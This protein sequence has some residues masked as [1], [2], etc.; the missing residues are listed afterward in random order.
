MASIAAGRTPHSRQTAYGVDKLI[1]RKDGSPVCLIRRLTDG[2]RE[3]R[4]PVPPFTV[5]AVFDAKA[6][7]IA[8]LATDERVELLPGDPFEV[9][10]VRNIF[11]RFYRDNWGFF[12][13]ARELNDKNVPSPRGSVWHMSTIRCVIQNS[14]YLGIGVTCKYGTG[15]LSFRAVGG[16]KE[17]LEPRPK[18]Y[19][20]DGS[21]MP[22]KMP[23][24]IIRP[25][26]DWYQV[27][28]PHLKDY[29]PEDLRAFALA[30]FERRCEAARS[31][32]PRRKDRLKKRYASTYF[33][34]G[35]LKLK[36]GNYPMVGVPSCRKA[37]DT[38]LKY[39]YY[40][41]ARAHNTPH[42]DRP[43]GQIRADLIEAEILREVQDVLANPG[44]VKEKIVQF[45][46]DEQAKKGGAKEK[47]RKLRRQ[48]EALEAK[49]MTL[50]NEVGPR[51]RE[52]FKAEV[53]KLEISL[54]QLETEIGQIEENAPCA[55][56]DPTKVSESVLSQLADLAPFLC[57]TNLPSLRAVMEALVS[58]MEFDSTTRTVDLELRLPSWAI[59]REKRLLTV[60]RTASTRSS[61]YAIHTNNE[62]VVLARVT[63]LSTYAAKYAG[64]RL[65]IKCHRRAA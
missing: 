44:P 55:I 25:S 5:E 18:G 3:R 37:E 32:K 52:I 33:L 40:S 9:E 57:E 59:T 26:E 39:R 46:R 21:G 62:G 65:C 23:Q 61:K 31:D 20:S 29:L 4:S 15:K 16:P 27:S 56:D 30:D 48:K 36:Q 10:T 11:A 41:A 49:Y 53:A 63:C 22:R 64:R 51:G 8:P 45:V 17:F 60:V 6:K 50:V 19:K 12:K 35:L 42:S 14:T 43:T 47:L 2:R 13:I 28:H 7:Q 34:S 38:V 1:V 54:S 24:S 58:K